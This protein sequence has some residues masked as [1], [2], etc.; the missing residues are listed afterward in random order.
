MKTDVIFK[1]DHKELKENCLFWYF[2]F[3]IPS[4]ES[5][6]SQG[7]NELNHRISVL[8]GIL[9]IIRLNFTW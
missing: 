8:E 7:L 3:I 5:G 6:V 1:L 4:I 2:Y 9:K